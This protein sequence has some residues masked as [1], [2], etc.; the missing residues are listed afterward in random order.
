M[1]YGLAKFGS[2]Y[3]IKSVNSYWDAD[4]MVARCIIDMSNMKFN[5][6]GLTYDLLTNE[7]RTLT[8]DKSILKW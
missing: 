4:S 8:V 6:D 5:V 3:T 7:K 1:F 2:N